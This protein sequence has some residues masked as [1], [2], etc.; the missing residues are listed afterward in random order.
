LVYD[1]DYICPDSIDS[2]ISPDQECDCDQCRENFNSDDFDDD[3]PN[4]G[5]CRPLNLTLKEEA[6][7]SQRLDDELDVI[8]K[9]REAYLKQNC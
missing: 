1:E 6:A 7:L 9:E 2:D 3:Y 5:D 8:A 4:N